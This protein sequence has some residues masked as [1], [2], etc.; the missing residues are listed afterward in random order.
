MIKKMRHYPVFRMCLIFFAFLN[1]LQGK[2]E[3][4]SHSGSAYNVD[5]LLMCVYD[6]FY[7]GKTKSRAFSV[8]SPGS[9]G[10]V[11]ALPDFRNAFFGNSLSVI[12]NRDEDLTVFFRSLH[13]DNGV[14]RTEFNGVIQKIVKNLTDFFLICLYKELFSGKDQLQADLP[15]GADTFKKSGGSLYGLIDVKGAEIHHPLFDI[16]FVE[17]Q[18]TT[19]KLFQAVC[20]R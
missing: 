10:F 6:F 11:K 20:F 5:V 19:G 14:I 7:N 13:N 17:S 2:D 1:T 4:C 16:E 12:F 8:P 18:K 15:G 3:F 9:V